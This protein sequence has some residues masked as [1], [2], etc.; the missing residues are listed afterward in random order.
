MSKF[1]VD[2]TIAFRSLVQHR[3]R[4]LFLGTAIAAVT[5][6]LVLLNGLSTGVRET[7]I[8]TAT[9]LSTGHVNIGG[10]FKV[11]AGQAAPVVTDYKRVIE[12]AKKTVPEMAFVVHRGRGW[13]KIVSDTGSMQMGVTGIDVRSEP[14]FASVLQLT[15]GKLDDL[16]E[17]GTILIFDNQA[18]KLG[19]KV[20][21][22]VTISAPTTRGTNNTVDVRVVAIAH[23]LG[24]LSTW[25][26]FIPIDTLRKLY[27][28]NQDSTGVVQIMLDRKD[29]DRKIPEISSRLR[30]ALEQAGYRMMEPDPRA[31]WMKFQS[32]SREDWTGQKLDVTSWEDEISFMTWT[33][34]ALQGMSVVLIAILIAIIIIGIMN[35]MWIAIRERTREIGTLRAIGMH[36]REVLWMF[37]LESIMLGLFAT[38]AGVAA[39]SAIASGLNAMHVHVPTGLQ[40]FLMSPYLHI[41]VHGSALVRSVIA[42]T[43]VTALAALYPSL[44]A[45]RLRPVV[46]MSHFG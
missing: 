10:F 12:V 3:R 6:L 32:V 26:S 46:A 25:N 1:F 35:T 34:K 16:A 8:D 44:R 5:A 13:A 36:R 7:M 21:D 23:S 27:Q 19:V 42:I 15:S 4:T 41:S 11:T 22:A 24:L 14:K 18:E 28:F 39:G 33:L 38:V 2:L 30:T 43:V 31:F 9:T 45:A 17:P 29:L 37:L 20:G 40:F